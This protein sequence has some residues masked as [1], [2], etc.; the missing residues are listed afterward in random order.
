MLPKESKLLE[1]SKNIILPDYS[2]YK[3]LALSTYMN[4]LSKIMFLCILKIDLNY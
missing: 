4:P 1:D 2:T 3:R